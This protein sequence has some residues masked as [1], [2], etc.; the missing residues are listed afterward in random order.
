MRY[1]IAQNSTGTHSFNAVEQTRATR[2]SYRTCRRVSK[3]SAWVIHACGRAILMVTMG[4]RQSLGLF[5]APLGELN[6]R[7]Y[8][9]S[10]VCHRAKLIVGVSAVSGAV[11]DRYGPR[12]SFMQPGRAGHRH[13]IDAGHEPGSASS[14]R[15]RVSAIVPERQ[16]LGLNR[17]RSAALTND[18]RV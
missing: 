10:M 1:A 7:H 5:I 14:S 11:A 2:A 8:T 15:W 4:A 3:R 18:K 16:F 9:I 6:G 17:A 12:R 13:G